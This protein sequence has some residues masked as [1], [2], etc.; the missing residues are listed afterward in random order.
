M[1]GERI[2][3]PENRCFRKPYNSTR[4]YINRRR[5]VKGKLGFSRE[6]STPQRCIGRCGARTR[7]TFSLLFQFRAYSGINFDNF[8]RNWLHSC[9]SE[10]RSRAAVMPSE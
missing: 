4:L 5:T 9:M 3:K 10:G 8:E 7:G 6:K 2:S 1:S